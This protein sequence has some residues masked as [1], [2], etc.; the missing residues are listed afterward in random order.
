MKRIEF[1]TGQLWWSLEQFFIRNENIFM[2]QKLERKNN[3]SAIDNRL[4]FVFYFST[5]W[6]RVFTFTTSFFFHELDECPSQNKYT[7]KKFLFLSHVVFVSFVFIAF[8]PFLAV[9][10]H[11]TINGFPLDNWLWFEDSFVHACV[12]VL[13][14]QVRCSS[15]MQGEI[16][17]L[18][19]NAS[20][21]TPQPQVNWNLSWGH[22]DWSSLRVRCGI[23]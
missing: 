9:E 1:R 13:S 12:R 8:A 17:S 7:E 4:N 11:F 14:F 23:Q 10:I 18:I 5:R 6:C 20:H 15:S 2:K 21:P 22:F 19:L 3:Q 16:L